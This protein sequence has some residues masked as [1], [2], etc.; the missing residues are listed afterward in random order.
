MDTITSS[1]GP[2]LIVVS[3]FVIL[4]IVLFIGWTVNRQKFQS[5]GQLPRLL[6]ERYD[7]GEIPKK[8]YE[9]IKREIEKPLNQLK[10]YLKIYK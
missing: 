10:Y 5:I 3:L 1:L 2:I 4:A 9:D 8:E 7:K 6:K